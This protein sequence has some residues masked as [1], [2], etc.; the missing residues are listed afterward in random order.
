[1]SHYVY[2]IECS[3]GHLY[4]GYTTDVKRRYQ[5]HIKG[6]RSCKYT[7]AFPPKRLVGYLEFNDKSSALKEE[8]RIKQ[9]SQKKKR[10]IFASC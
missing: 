2:L 6:T 4:T 3:N 1:M 7:R 8:Y 5:E 10:E 9:L